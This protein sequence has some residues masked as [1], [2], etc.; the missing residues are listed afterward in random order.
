[1]VAMSTNESK[2]IASNLA[3]DKNQQIKIQTEQYD[4]IA[5]IKRAIGLYEKSDSIK[6]VMPNN[7]AKRYLSE[8]RGIKE[9][10]TRYQLS[11]DLRN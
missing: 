4:E 10:L 7:V 8:H 5:K 6:Y 2:D 9:I 3:A 11:N 1:M